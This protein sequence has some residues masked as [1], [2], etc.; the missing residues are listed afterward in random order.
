MTSLIIPGRF[1]GPPGS[2]NGGYCCGA[3]AGAL[4][5][6]DGEAA[7]VTLRSPPPL[8]TP[9]RVE[10]DGDGI[11]VVSGSTL[12]AEAHRSELDLTVP[13]AVSFAEASRAQILPAE[14]PFPGCFVC[15]PDHES[16]LRIF[17]GRVPG[18]KMHA[19]PWIPDPDLADNG[20]IARPVVWAS[21]DCPGGWVRGRDRALLGRLEAVVRSAPAPGDRCVAMAWLIDEPS[22]RRWIAGTALYGENGVLHGAARA[23]WVVPR[24]A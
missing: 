8:D 20:A 16:G 2:A 21:L 17:V 5:L 19:G 15:G 18:R 1:N 9:M 11:R 22:E 24:P 10:P 4:G 23:T 6:G 14:H 12:V 13:E 3:V 7:T